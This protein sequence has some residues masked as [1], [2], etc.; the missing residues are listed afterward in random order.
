MKKI[1]IFLS[2]FLCSNLFGQEEK[3][4]DSISYLSPYRFVPKL[5]LFLDCDYCD[6]SYIQQESIKYFEFVRDQKYADVHIMVRTQTNGSGGFEHEL[7]YFGKNYYEKAYNKHSFSTVPTNSFS[8]NRDLMLQ[9]IRMGSSIF[10][11]K[12][13]DRYESLIDYSSNNEND[14]ISKPKPVTVNNIESKDKWNSWVFS[15]GVNGGYSGQET[16][17]NSNFGVNF[18]MKRVTDKNKFLIRTSYDNRKSDYDYG[19]F[20]ISSTNKTIDVNIYDAFSISNHWSVGAFLEGGRSTYANQKL[21]I[22]FKPAIEYSFFDYKQSATKQIT[23][24]YRVG[25]VN[26][27]Y[28]EKTIF[29]KDEEFLWEQSAELSGSVQQKWGSVNGS[30]MYDSYLNDSSLNAFNFRLSTN[31]RI[32]SGLTFNISGD[33]AI[34]KNQINLAGGDLSLDELLLSQKQVNSGYNFYTRVGLNFSFGSMFSSVINPR[35]DF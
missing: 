18:S 16:S 35:F 3:P 29:N 7:E 12:H 1:L 4:Q 21:Y 31:F 27:N 11:Y 30:I 5:K 15:I 17:E 33:Y 19:D 9:N 14:S 26:Y 24:S 13:Y 28:D 6:V 34:T 32:T 20:K 8:E 2:I 22:K 25:G 10:L 23:L